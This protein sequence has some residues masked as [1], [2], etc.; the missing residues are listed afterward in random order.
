MDFSLSFYRDSKITRIL[1][2]SLG[3]GAL[4]VMIT[5]LS[6]SGRDIPES[7]NALKYAKRVRFYGFQSLVTDSGLFH[8][9][10]FLRLVI[11]RTIPL[12]IMLVAMIVHCCLL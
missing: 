11:S 6:P 12:L 10:V 3:G 9:R 4:T 8:S 7:L 1:K 2:D 5:C